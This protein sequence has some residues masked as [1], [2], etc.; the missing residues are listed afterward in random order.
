MSQKIMRMDG[1]FYGKRVKFSP[2]FLSGSIIF[3]LGFGIILTDKAKTLP[4]LP[5]F[6][7]IEIY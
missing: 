7:G 6:L 2:F 5:Y 4:S 1:G 3:F